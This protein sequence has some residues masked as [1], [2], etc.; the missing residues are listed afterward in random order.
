MATLADTSVLLEDEEWL[1]WS[2]AM[3]AH[4]AVAGHALLTRAPARY[5]AYFPKLRIVAPSRLV[6][7]VRARVDIRR[8]TRDDAAP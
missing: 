5:R 4:A 8:L 3:L 1:D 6:V 2:A 7:A